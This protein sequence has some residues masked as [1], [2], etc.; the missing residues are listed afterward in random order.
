MKQQIA[1]FG[2]GLKS[3][4]TLADWDGYLDFRAAQQAGGDGTQTVTGAYAAVAWLYRC[5]NLRAS[6]VANVPFGI[7]PKGSDPKDAQETP[8]PYPLKELLWRSETAICL[9]GAN[10]ILK[11]KNV[12][13]LVAGLQWLNPASMKVERSS[14]GI[15]GFTQRVETTEIKYAPEDLIYYALFNPTDD[16]GPGIS[17]ARVALEAAGLAQNA[18]VWA[19]SFFRNSAFPAIVLMSDQTM[20]DDQQK[21]LKGQFNRLAQG[22]KRAFNSIVLHSGVKMQVVGQPVKD[23]AMP[24]LM[25]QVRGQ[26]CS[27]CGVPETMLSDAANFATAKEHKQSFVL[28]TVVPQCQW[29]A[30]RWNEQWLHPM[31]Q[32]LRFRPEEL[33]IVQEDEAD[34]AGAAKATL[35]A[36]R[37]A[38][39]VGVVTDLEMRA[40]ANSVFVGMGLPALDKNWKP[41]PKPKPVVPVV[42]TPEQSAPMDQQPLV[43]QTA[44][45]PN[46]LMKADIEKWQRKCEKAGKAKPFESENIPAGIKAAIHARLAEDPETAWDFLKK[47]DAH[48]MAVRYAA[49]KRLKG[50]IAKE[51]ERQW[52]IAAEAINAGTVWDEAAFAAQ[53]RNSMDNV[54]A[55]I[56]TEHALRLAV[57]IGIDFDVAVINAAAWQW[58]ERFS[59]HWI[60]DITDTTRSIVQNA[61]SKFVST[62]GMTMGDLRDALEY[63]F[64][65]VRAQMIG[66]TETTR[67]FSAASQIYQDMLGKSGLNFE[68]IFR[69]AMDEKVCEI[70]GPL[71]DKP[72]NEW[73]NAGAPPLHPNCRCWTTLQYVGRSSD[74]IPH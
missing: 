14:Q 20:T 57:E 73:G 31:G 74:S 13:G 38:Y 15:T 44:P 6:G 60:Q 59:Y 27:A 2:G 37:V 8:W 24:E 71:E 54:L 50:A 19:S 65:P 25:N 28:D 1:L 48:E 18:N 58:A 17:P 26:I 47:F 43:D 35:D 67:S 45:K 7:Y 53:V 9:Y 62:P 52:T 36:A 3:G 39:D 4:V 69:T 40:V 41:E 29:H 61:V 64:S 33:E 30:E 66:V 56:A 11:R 34:K 55:G 70:C 16:L 12:A 23:M 72:E 51:F 68:K 5:I 32:E 21:E 63:G 49:E 22:V 10:Y 46:A 42:V